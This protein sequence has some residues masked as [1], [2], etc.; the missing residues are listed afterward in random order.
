MQNKINK[1]ATRRRLG[2]AI[3]YLECRAGKAAGQS[4][5][6]R[7]SLV[8][9][10]RCAGGH[11]QHHKPPLDHFERSLHFPGCLP[12][13]LDQRSEAPGPQGRRG[14]GSWVQVPALPLTLGLI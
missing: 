6:E 12:T 4:E 1:R 8:R 2:K 5:T 13:S 14:P 10:H 11:Q 3:L 7:T 9:A